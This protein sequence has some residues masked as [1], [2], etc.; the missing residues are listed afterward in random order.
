MSKV[1]EYDF[2]A[3]DKHIAWEQAKNQQILE[4]RSS[5]LWTNWAKVSGF[6]L[7]GLG[8]FVLLLS[9]AYYIYM[10]TFSDKAAI[11]SY[12]NTNE[13]ELTALIMK[14]DEIEKLIK[15]VDLSGLEIKVD[16]L[17]N[18]IDNQPLPESDS[19]TLSKIAES[20]NLNS[21]D[22]L[23]QTEQQIFTKTFTVFETIDDVVTGRTY[24]PTNT[25]S[26]YYQYCY[27]T[28]PLNSDSDKTIRTE[29]AFKNEDDEIF[30]Y[31]LEDELIKNC[32]FIDGVK[33]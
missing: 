9:I 22:N 21:N 8:F 26:P 20:E 31:N 4:N 25:S 14:I 13:K 33:K 23:Q 24:S 6:F 2:N 12:N 30:Y 7:L 28:E 27:K 17:K 19:L 15:K 18:R 3:I 10:A 32:R 5:L 1:S 16:E 29:L 11:I